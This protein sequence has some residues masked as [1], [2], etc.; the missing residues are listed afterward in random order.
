MTLFWIISAIVTFFCLRW[1]MTVPCLKPV[2]S[3]LS[4]YRTV[5]TYQPIGLK[6]WSLLLIILVS[7]V[8]FLNLICLICGIIVA[9]AH[10]ST[11]DIDWN[12]LFPPGKSKLM[13]FLTKSV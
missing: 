1:L 4:G 7:L 3:G 11:E 13:S 8:P 9:L 2:K 10:R 5:N 6:I 12:V